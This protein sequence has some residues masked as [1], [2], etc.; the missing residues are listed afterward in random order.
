MMRT[1]DAPPLGGYLEVNGRRL[2]LM[3]SGH[4][5]P[6]T[7]FVPGAGSFGLDFLLAHQFVSEQTTSLLYDRAGTGWS[8]DV[9]LPRSIDE[10]T[11][12][13][14]DLLE[15]LSLPGPYL[16]VGHSLGGAYVQRYAQRFPKSVAGLLLL[17]P[18]HEDWDE[19]M[20]QHLK[21][22]TTA[23]DAATMP[24]LP[25]Q[26]MD[27][28]RAM[29]LEALAG[30]PEPIRGAIVA[31]HASP[32]RLVTGLHEGL[33]VLAVLED[34]RRG[35][36]RPNVPVTILSAT[37]IDAQQLMFATED[38]LRE[39]IRASERLYAALAESTPQGEHKTLADASH[40]TMPMARPDAVA[41]AVTDLLGRIKA[42]RQRD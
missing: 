37:G 5:D 2:W 38:Q 10:A 33:N 15:V 39:Q 28:L 3:R 25:A 19:Y 34:L 40:A 24:D 35:G 9:K 8:E 4:G 14:R 17:D 32:A 27:Q 1:M 23:S 22:A 7:V 13:L 20:P 31:R 6:T 16:L 18:L 12:E 26:I 11:D 21:L 36:P 41:D 30:F 42:G 29:L